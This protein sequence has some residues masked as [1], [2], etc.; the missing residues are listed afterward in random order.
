M[1]RPATLGPSGYSGTARTLTSAELRPIVAEAIRR[2]AAAGLSQAQVAQLKAVQFVVTDLSATAPGEVGL[3]LNGVVA[4]DARAAGYGWFID[5][6]P[7]SDSEFSHGKPPAGMDLLTVVMHE[8]GHELGLPDLDASEHS[9]DLM[10]EGLAPGVRLAHV[11]AYDLQLLGIA[12]WGVGR[13]RP[14]G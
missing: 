1:A 14:K 8:L 6:T 2:W 11:S 9:G 12:G 7:R 13:G 4:L 5:P 10:A 3:A